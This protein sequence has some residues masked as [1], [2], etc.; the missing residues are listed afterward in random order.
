MGTTTP[1]EPAAPAVTV[2][3]FASDNTAPAH[4]AVLEALARANTGHARGYGADELTARATARLQALLGDE[5]PVAFV[6]GGTGANVVGLATMLRP[7]EAVIC[8]TA[9]HINVD[10][11]GAPERFTGS[12]LLA[13]E[14][15]HA[16]LTPELVAPRLT[17]FGNEHAVQP[18]VLSLTQTTEYGTLYTVDEIR[19][20]S[21]LAHRH[22]LLVQM[23]G[24]RLANAAA[25]L[26]VPVRTFTRDA[27]VD[28]LSFGFTKNGAVGVEAVCWLTPS[29]GAAAKFVRKQSMQLASKHRYLAAQ[30]DALLE[31]DRW[32]ALAAHANAMAQRLAHAVRECPGV[33]LTQPV[34]GNALFAT[35]PRPAIARLQERFYFYVWREE[36][37]E[38]R[39]MTSWDR[40]PAEV[41][42]FAAAIREAC[43]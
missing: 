41:D 5:V 43:A 7:H 19:A 40:T 10:E 11:C 35:L 26:G 31:D 23:D 42:A 17:G 24:A 14:A 34:Q 32:L 1:T 28:V 2:H 22:G 9:A 6:W 15:P 16:K 27:G 30:V 36:L 18:R 20:L 4:P 39:W 12:K 13:I 38:V 3:S 29:L 8:S 33:R 21:D 25:S 37:A